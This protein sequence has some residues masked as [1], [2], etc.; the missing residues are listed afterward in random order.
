ML[1]QRVCFSLITEKICRNHL[2][3]ARH[4][5]LLPRED[6]SR[7]SECF[8]GGLALISVLD[9]KTSYFPRPRK[10][11]CRMRNK[12]ACSYACNVQKAIVTSQ[13]SLNIK[14]L[15]PNSYHSLLSL[16]VVGL[17][18]EVSSYSHWFHFSNTGN[19]NKRGLLNPPFRNFPLRRSIYWTKLVFI[20][21][22]NTF[23]FC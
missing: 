14:R 20:I 13:S 19:L 22:N 9:F 3:P 15:L 12:G 4:A 11:W 6:L 5:F 1:R 17:N 10:R 8:D 23:F 16:S 18:V 21:K 2:N 7:I